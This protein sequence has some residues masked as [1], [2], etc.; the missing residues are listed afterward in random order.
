MSL[1]ESLARLYALSKRGAR[2]DL[3]G[4]REACAIEGEPQDR[5][6]SVHVAGTNG[7]GSVCATLESIARAAGL[8]VGLYTSPHLVKF[9]ERIRIDGAPIEDAVLEHH[10]RHVLDRHPSLT[11]FEVATLA[12]FRAF[13]EAQI[14][15]AILEVGLGGRLDA[16]NVVRRPLATAVTTI[17]YDHTEWLGE[18][19]EAIAGEKAGILKPGVPVTTGPL[20]RAAMQVVE[21][22]ATGL[23]WRV[24]SEI[25]H[26]AHGDHLIVRGPERSISVTP[27]LLGE[28]QRDNAA[29]AIGLSWLL[30]AED[31]SLGLEDPA[32]ARGVATVEWP[33]RLETI[34]TPEGRV[35]LDGAHN[36]QGARALG[37]A[38]DALGAGDRALVFGAM[39][40]KAWGTMVREL[41]PRFAHRVYMAPVVGTRAA[42]DPSSL[43]MLDPGGE[44][45]VDLADAIA[46]ARAAVGPHGL[47]VIAGSLYLVGEARARL[48]GLER[49]PQVG[50]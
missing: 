49:D 50:L 3:E 37:A 20:P 48:L 9:A 12:A 14:D 24:G 4:M 32:I 28:H 7:K 13:D 34:D 16:T 45:A 33:G 47:V 27:R 46:R 40:D 1:S 26:E 19:I 10:L 30:R 25:V 44:I 35:L 22:R 39:A 29:I 21:E 15:L 8:R 41:A 43:A 23:L 31:P 38:V 17:G 18:T 36:E 42:A 11:F 6:R 2:R 5:V